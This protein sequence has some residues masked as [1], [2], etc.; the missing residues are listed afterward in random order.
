MTNQRHTARRLDEHTQTTLV[1]AYR[2][3]PIPAQELDHAARQ[4]LTAMTDPS[5]PDNWLKRPAT[6]T[7]MHCGTTWKTRLSLLACSRYC[8]D[9]CREASRQLFETLTGE[10][11]R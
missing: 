4:L 9:D 1:L 7:C 3:Q 5:N 6:R 10:T 11:I 8:S 2:N